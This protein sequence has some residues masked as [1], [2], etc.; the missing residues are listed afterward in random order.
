M[1]AT[2]KIGDTV[3]LK[4][5][6]PLMTVTKDVGAKR[7]MCEWFADN[8]RDVATFAEVALEK[9]DRTVPSRM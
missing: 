8:K 2:Y 6:G 3:R 1:A 7:V 4:S 9:A 5:G